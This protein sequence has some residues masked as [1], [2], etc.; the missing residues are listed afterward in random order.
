MSLSCC[1]FLLFLFF[2]P[3]SQHFA[4]PVKPLNGDPVSRRPPPISSQD[5]RSLHGSQR[6]SVDSPWFK[7]WSLA[8]S[9]FVFQLSLS[10]TS[11]VYIFYQNQNIQNAKVIIPCHI[12]IILYLLAQFTFM[13]VYLGIFAWMCGWYGP[14]CQWNVTIAIPNSAFPQDVP[15][16]QAIDHYWNPLKSIKNPY[17]IHN[18]L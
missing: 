10:K 1:C 4:Q 8:L 2:S 6:T 16:N 3:S 9:I 7:C 11:K 15:L 18:P 12:Y 5:R 14:I 13:Q 17:L